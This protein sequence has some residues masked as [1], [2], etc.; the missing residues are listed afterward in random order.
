MRCATLLLFALCACTTTAPTDPLPSWQEGD[1]KRAIL[2]FVEEATREGSERY[3]PPAERIATFD[4][5]GTLWTEKPVYFQVAFALERVREL[6][7]QHPEWKQT[8]PFRTVL[9]GDPKAIAKLSHEDFF[10]IVSITHA[11]MT[12]AQF[13]A[14]ARSWLEEA[15]HPRFDRPYPTL[16]YQPM[17]ELLRLLEDRGFQVWICTGGTRGFVRA[18]SEETYGIPPERVIGTTLR[19]EF[20]EVDG[21]WALQ[22]KPELVVPVN[23]KAGKPVHIGR[24]IGRRPVIAVGNSD[25]DIE[26]LQWA[27]DPALR[28]LVHHDDAKREY[29]YRKGT[30]RALEVAARDDWIVVS[31]RRDFKSIYPAR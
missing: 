3:V 24:V 11:G 1:S 10:R 8:E 29:S 13:R 5:D 17:L 6:A 2:A 15:R 12:E 26:M 27:R 19:S 9:G 31:M 21:A 16:I 14:I 4:N 20:R 25:G 22:R 18:L 23:D 28:I 7:P 30:E